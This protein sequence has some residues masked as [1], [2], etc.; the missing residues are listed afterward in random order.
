MKNYPLLLC[1]QFFGALGDNALLAVILGQLTFLNQNG[2][3]SGETLRF[4]NA[5]FSTML[6]VPYVV[7]APWVG[8]LNDRFPKTTLLRVG[9]GFKIFGTFLCLLCLNHPTFLQGIGYFIVGTGS[10]VYSPAKYGILPEIVH[11]DKLV[12]ANGMVEM[13]TMVAILTGVIGGSV[14]IDHLPVPACYWIL[15]GGYLVSLGAACAMSRT[16]QTMGLKSSESLK[17]FFSHVGFLLRNG[18]LRNILIGTTLFWFLGSAVKMNFQ[19]WGL[20]VLGLKD[21][22]QISL[23][24][25]WLSIGLIVG[26]AVSGYFYKTGDL[27][28]IRRYGFI[29]GL[30][31]LLLG[32][33]ST[34]GL[35]VAVLIVTGAMGGLY[36][37]PQ[38]AAFQA[39]TPPEKLGKTV[40]VQ[41]FVEN[42]AMCVSGGFVGLIA[43]INCPVQG[44]FVVL[45]LIIGCVILSLRFNNKSSNSGK[46]SVVNKGI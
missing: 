44:V 32:F 35:V 43:Y 25:L 10:C 5:L 31:V 17:A 41:N 23:L 39:E 6:F 29:L 40:A 12:K 42:I 33:I 2:D 28:H 15:I 45:A 3:M 9:N 37:I 34:Y 18:R 16:S 38:N 26:N 4:Y 20:Q 24:G 21:N 30:G 1:G 36:L 27:R 7:F 22:T 46:E 14:L 13:L 19:P 8:Y 11:R